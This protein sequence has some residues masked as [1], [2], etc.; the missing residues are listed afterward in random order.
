MRSRTSD[1]ASVKGKAIEQASRFAKVRA[2]HVWQFRTI[3][4][5]AAREKA[6]EEQAAG[7]T[8]SSVNSMK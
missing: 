3:D 4:E 8:A 2:A 6:K 1:P 7:L 5:I